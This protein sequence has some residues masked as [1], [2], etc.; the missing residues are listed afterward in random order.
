MPTEVGNNVSDMQSEELKTANIMVAGKTGTGKSTLLNAIFGE[1]LATTGTG[2]PVTEHIDEYQHENIPIHIWDTVGL[3]LDSEKTRQSIDE[4]KHTIASKSESKDEFDQIHAIWYCINSGSNRYEGAEL[5]F[6]RE[7][8]SIGVPFTIVLT[9]CYGAKKKIGEFEDII[10]KINIEMG[11]SDIS[12]I[13][14][15]AQDYEV[16]LDEDNIV[17]KPAFGLEELVNHTM[18]QLPNYVQSGF[19]AAQKVSEALKHVECERLIWKYV[20]R[21]QDNYWS[22]LKI[23]NW[24]NVPIINIL[25]TDAHIKELFKDISK[26]YNTEIPD[27]SLGQIMVELGGLSPENALQGLLS[28]IS[29]RFDEN[30]EKFYKKNA[31]GDFDKD[32][33]KLPKNQRVARMM[34]LYGYTFLESIEAYWERLRTEKIETLRTKIDVLVGIIREKCEEINGRNKRN[35]AKGE[36]A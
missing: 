20:E 27:N 16:E 34:V 11:L 35:A 5:E 24:D 15:L 9:Q 4:I 14:V 23:I 13:R 1:D 22:K 30:V 6:I 3:E 36:L 18:E 10:N 32:F 26:I 31:K 21:V 8:Y 19:I 33:S 12:I 2:K 7:L 17:T 28:P 29:K 25:T